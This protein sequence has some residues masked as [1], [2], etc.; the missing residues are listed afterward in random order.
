MI[1]MR[2]MISAGT[3]ISRVIFTIGYHSFR[4]RRPTHGIIVTETTRE[5]CR[6]LATVSVYFCRKTKKGALRGAPY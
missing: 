5:T 2:I 1:Q 3:L 4:R 6:S